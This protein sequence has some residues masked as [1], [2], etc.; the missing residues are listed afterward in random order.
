MFTTQMAQHMKSNCPQGKM[1]L[2]LRIP[3]PLKLTWAYVPRTTE[4]TSPCQKR[5]PIPY[6]SLMVSIKSSLYIQTNLIHY[7]KA[8]ISNYQLMASR[9]KLSRYR[10]ATTQSGRY[11]RE[12]NIS[13]STTI[14]M[15]QISLSVKFGYG[16]ITLQGGNRSGRGLQAHR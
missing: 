6:S 12:P 5:V 14:R 8:K 1:K 3:T 15:S 11:N 13:V 16:V 10:R 2:G 9:Y 4:R 7:T